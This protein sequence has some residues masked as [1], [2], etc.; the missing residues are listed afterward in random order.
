M[1]EVKQAA[2]TGLAHTLGG[3]LEGKHLFV[4]TAESCTGGGIA[5]AITS[6]DGSSK[7]FDR[8]FVSYSNESKRAML[9]VK[10]AS[11]KKFGAVSE[12]VVKEM[13]LG[14]FKK[15]DAAFTVAVSGIAGP[16]GG[17]E[18][19]PIGTVWFAWCVEGEVESAVM[20]FPGDR[21]EVRMGGYDHRFARLGNPR[22]KVA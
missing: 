15:S 9:S 7:W 19:K 22:S 20:C 2:I 16:T 12:R 5:E 6:V 11:I 1:Y 14:A 17:T 8:A 4:A 13:A 18:E 3:L 21:R 10:V